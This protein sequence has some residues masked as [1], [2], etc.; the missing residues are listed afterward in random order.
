[1]SEMSP[2]GSEEAR[3]ISEDLEGYLHVQDEACA[4]EGPERVQISSL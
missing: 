1:M 3:D 2:V 4:Q